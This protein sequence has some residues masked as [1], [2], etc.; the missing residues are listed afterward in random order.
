MKIRPLSVRNYCR[1]LYN[2]L[3]VCAI[4]VNDELAHSTHFSWLI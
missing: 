4:Q 1:K 3:V 2:N